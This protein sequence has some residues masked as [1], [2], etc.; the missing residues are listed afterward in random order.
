MHDIIVSDM[1]N[2]KSDINIK[3]DLYKYVINII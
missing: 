1:E 2:D 3:L